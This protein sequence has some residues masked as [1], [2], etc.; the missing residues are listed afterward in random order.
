MLAEIPYYK[1]PEWNQFVIDSDGNMI[2]YDAFGNLE[3]MS[4]HVI[5]ESVYYGKYIGKSD[6]Y[7]EGFSDK[8]LAEDA[9]AQELVDARD[10]YKIFYEPEKIFKVD[11]VFKYPKNVGKADREDVKSM[12]EIKQKEHYKALHMAKKIS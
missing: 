6:R 3:I 7:D 10:S 9:R 4:T 1:N 5:D 2:S 8:V 12:N 11:K